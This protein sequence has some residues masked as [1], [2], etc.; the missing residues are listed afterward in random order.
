LNPLKKLFKQTFIYGLATVL[1]KMLSFL[2]TPLYVA[3]L[4][5][6][7]EFGE[8]SII[9]AW[10]AIFNVILAYGMETA[11]FR[12]FHKAANKEN[13]IT[14][15]LISIAGSTLIF[16]IL[17]FAFQSFLANITEIDLKYIRYTIIILALDALV[18]IPFAWLRAKEKPMR[19]A[20]I[21]VANVF[22]NLSLNVFFLKILPQLVQENPTGIWSTLY[23]PNFE[24]SYIFISN[25]IASGLTLLFMLRLYL[26]KAY[27]FDTAMWK[28]MI[29]YAMPVMVAGIAYTINEVFGRIMLKKLLPEAI[30]E[31]K[32]GE[33]S[34]CLKIAVFMTL[35]ATAFRMG[36]EPF[37]FSHA[38]EENPQKTYA[39]ITNYFVILGSIILLGVVVFAD[40]LKLLIVPNETYWEAMNVVPI[41]IL[42]AFFLGIYHNLSVWYKVTDRTK[43][44][45]YI[46]IVGAVLTIAINFF[47]IEKIG[48][49]ASAIA[50][51]SAYGTMMV[52]SYLFGKKYYPVPYNM[53]KI[54]FY[55]GVS[56]LFS[57]I[58]FY[59]FRG[60]L[61]LGAALLL[62]FLGMVYKLENDKLKKIF[63]KK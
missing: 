44:G 4:P 57:A 35:F 3:T 28:K 56:I 20:W 12:F 37:F 13:V 61:Y 46:S 58:S 45:A 11:F 19:Y 29:G 23:Q 60:N 26:R 41:V 49:L 30:A 63:L 24:I 52:L 17:A 14:T 9:F 27:V 47:L 62:V 6:T 34:A 25:L 42:A 31:G 16:L 8:V 43:F 38:K 21:K 40:V 7:D 10:F 59:G 53:R 36:I 51:L 1:P 18:I 32:I 15:S 39:Q 2:L 48:Y 22:I 33:Y 55:L 54:S 50:T 5:S